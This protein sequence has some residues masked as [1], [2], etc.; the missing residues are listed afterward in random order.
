MA[1]AGVQKGVTKNCCIQIYPLRV[2]NIVTVANI[3]ESFYGRLSKVDLNTME[4][5]FINK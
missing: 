1:K 4:L 5:Q 2:K 3:T